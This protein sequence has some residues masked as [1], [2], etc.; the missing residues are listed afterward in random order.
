MTFQTGSFR[1]T[2]EC[3]AYLE[4]TIKSNRRGA[5]IAAVEHKVIGAVGVL[6]TCLPFKSSQPLCFF[7]NKLGYVQSY[8]VKGFP[9]V[10]GDI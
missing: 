10:S 6:K 5:E 8:K 9:L 7:G 2:Y 3:A 4:F 1:G